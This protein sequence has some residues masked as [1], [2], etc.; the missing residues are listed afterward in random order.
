MAPLAFH[1]C[2]MLAAMQRG[3]LQNRSVRFDSWVPRSAKQV[4]YPAQSQDLQAF[5]TRRKLRLKPFKA[6]G[7]G[8]APQRNCS[9]AVSAEHSRSVAMAIESLPSSRAS[10]W[11]CR[12]RKRL[13]SS[14]RLARCAA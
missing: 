9:G 13:P 3:G 6:A 4:D 8:S 5:A 2:W 14:D 1:A 12:L 10:N 7:N 11:P